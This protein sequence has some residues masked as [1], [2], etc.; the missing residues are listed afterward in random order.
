[1]VFTSL[2]LWVYESIY[3]YVCVCVCVFE[4]QTVFIIFSTQVYHI[5]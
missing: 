2:K 3:I 1:M 4:M 5:Q